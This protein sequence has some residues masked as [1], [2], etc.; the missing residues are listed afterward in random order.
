M[1]KKETPHE[2]DYE[3]NDHC[4]AHVCSC[5]DHKFID[6]CWC[7]WSKASGYQELAEMGESMAGITRR[8]T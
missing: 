7:G 2:H 4:A 3:W 6:H 8:Y 5:G 1:K